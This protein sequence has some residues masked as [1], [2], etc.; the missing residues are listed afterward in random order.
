MIEIAIAAPGGRGLGGVER[1]R[2][3]QELTAA[4]H[5][6]PFSWPQ[7]PTRHSFVLN[8]HRRPVAEI[9][10]CAARAQF[11]YKAYAAASLRC[12]RFIETG[13]PSVAA[14]HNI[15]SGSHRFR[16]L[17]R[18]SKLPNCCRRRWLAISNSSRCWPTC[19]AR[20][21]V[22]AFS[23]DCKSGPK[24]SRHG[25]NVRFR[26]ARFAV[27]C[28]SAWGR[29][30]ARKSCCVGS[31]A[32]S[33]RTRCKPTPKSGTECFR[34]LPEVQLRHHGQPPLLK[35]GYQGAIRTRFSRELKKTGHR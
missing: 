19:G 31:E 29:L 16:S 4:S 5:Q 6:R 3:G 17:P 18:R 7:L 24:N 34:I 27:T 30:A 15:V 20:E 23:Q 8:S 25:V 28:E 10:L 32:S 1:G 9:G 35:G 21:S 13:S 26:A 2:L 33:N 22:R 11:P 14:T 12:S